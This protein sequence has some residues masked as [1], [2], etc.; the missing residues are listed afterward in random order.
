MVKLNKII[1]GGNKFLSI[2]KVKLSMCC[3]SSQWF[4]CV[5]MWLGLLALVLFGSGFNPRTPCL[6]GVSPT[7]CA[8]VSRKKKNLPSTS[9]PLVPLTSMW[10][11]WLS[12][13]QVWITYL[14]H[15]GIIEDPSPEWLWLGD[16][17]KFLIILRLC[18]GLLNQLLPLFSAG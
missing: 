9:K 3:L 18:L 6:G 8:G 17:N 7:N 12:V 5:N 13:A 10:V 15:L 14:V 2:L 11:V 16:P 1:G 4:V